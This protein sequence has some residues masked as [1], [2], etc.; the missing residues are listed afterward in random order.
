MPRGRS[1]RLPILRGMLAIAFGAA[2][3]A[4]ADT[5]LGWLARLFGI[6]AAADGAVA[7][8]GALRHTA[9]SIPMW[10]LLTRGLFGITAGYMVVHVPTVHPIGFYALLTAWAL[11]TGAFEIVAGLYGYQRLDGDTYQILYGI[12]TVVLGMVLLLIP[13]TGLHAFFPLISLNIVMAGTLLLLL[14]L[15]TE[16]VRSDP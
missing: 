13:P 15:R 10:G 4:Y 9:C 6:Y 14:G 7:I 12:V 5:T 8:A 3:M 2:S 11:L 1:W 16:A